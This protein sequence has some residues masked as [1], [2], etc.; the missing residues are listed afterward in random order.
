MH[1]PADLTPTLI[2]TIIKSATSHT[3]QNVRELE[4][5]HH[6]SSE[7]CFLTASILHQL[8]LRCRAQWT[9]SQLS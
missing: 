6:F 7:V 4:I 9:T 1:R 8:T 2:L 3:L 5:A